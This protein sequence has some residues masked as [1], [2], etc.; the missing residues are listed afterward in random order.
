LIVTS[1]R[2]KGQYL[3]GSVYLETSERSA[4]SQLAGEL[5]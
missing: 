4:L 1:E 3:F 5:L 2:F